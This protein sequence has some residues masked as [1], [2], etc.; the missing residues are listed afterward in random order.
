[1]DWRLIP[2]LLASGVMVAFGIGALARPAVLERLGVRA[3]SPLG[4]SE[5]RAVFG[6]M[7]IAL[8][9][10]AIVLREPVVFLMLGIAWFGD[11][12]ARL[13]AVALDRVPANEAA[14]VLSIA[15]VL[16]GA[17]ASGYWLA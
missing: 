10:A 14:L 15:L 13:A 17:L 8:G 6:G 16:G 9:L 7:F 3:F 1:M 12:I 11:V 4:S 5:I 2:A